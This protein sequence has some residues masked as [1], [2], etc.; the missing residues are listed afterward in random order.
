M[1]ALRGFN[2][3]RDRIYRA[4]RHRT[5]LAGLWNSFIEDEP[6]D[7][8]HEI[9]SNGAGTINMVARYERMP[10]E[11]SLELGEILYQLRAALDGSIYAYAVAVSGQDPPQNPSALEFVIRSSKADFDKCVSRQ[12]APLSSVAREFLEGLQPF[13]TPDLEEPLL[14]YNYNRALQMLNDWARLDRHRKLHVLGAWPSDAKPVAKLSPQCSIKSLEVLSGVLVENDSTI[15]RFSLDGYEPGMQ[16]G[17]D[18]HVILDMAV[19][20]T[21]LPRADNDI[22]ALRLEAM[23]RATRFV[24]NQLES[25]AQQERGA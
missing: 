15:A 24:V 5:A 20:E 7:A 11:F 22:L 12:L 13:S 6:Y 2:Y 23:I 1:C 10:S 16:V 14:V 25:I 21:P 3:G 19:D 17:F 4:E 18:L 9:D 8:I